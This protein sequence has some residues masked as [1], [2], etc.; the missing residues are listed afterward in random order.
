L[1][2]SFCT[3]GARNIMEKWRLRGAFD[4]TVCREIEGVIGDSNAW[5]DEKGQEYIRR[6]V[7]PRMRAYTS[8]PISWTTRWNHVTMLR[9]E[10]LLGTKIQCRSRRTF[11]RNRSE[12]AAENVLSYE[13]Q[14]DQKGLI[15]TNLCEDWRNLRASWISTDLKFKEIKLKISFN[16]QKPSYR[17]SLWK[18]FFILFFELQV[19]L[20]S[21]NSQVSSI[22]LEY[23]EF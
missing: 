2:K 14:G 18:I 15:G 6:L 4:Y 17:V 19:S 11:V 12:V 21:R 22:L 23:R 20:K 7:S 13:R 5:V 3:F 16:F 10:N 8:G 1:D 9:N